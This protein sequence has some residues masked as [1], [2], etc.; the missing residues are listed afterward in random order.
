M[1]FP[2]SQGAFGQNLNPTLNRVEIPSILGTINTIIQSICCQPYLNPYNCVQKIKNQLV[3]YGIEFGT[4][5]FFGD[6]GGATLEA[7]QYPVYGQD[8]HGHISATDLAKDKIIGGLAIRFNWV[9]IKG[10]YTIE[11]E[12]KHRMDTN[13]PVITEP[14]HEEL[15][16]KWTFA[17]ML[18][19]ERARVRT[20]RIGKSYKRKYTKHKYGVAT[21]KGYS[22]KKFGTRTKKAPRANFS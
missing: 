15:A 6:E 1:T 2:A 19:K 8:I 12:L 3:K 10:L 18:R 22:H 17:G 21:S 13:L 9:R 4:P 16:E 20:H 14:V 11:C 7:E 5:A